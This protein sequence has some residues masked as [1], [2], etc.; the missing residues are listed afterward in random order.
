M[1]NKTQTRELKTYAHTP[2][3][4]PYRGHIINFPM[5]WHYKRTT[6]WERLPDK[7]RH[8][9]MLN[10]L[11][12]LSSPHL[13]FVAYPPETEGFLN[14]VIHP[15]FATWWD[16]PEHWKS[17]LRALMSKLDFGIP[18]RASLSIRT[19]ARCT[20]NRKL[21]DFVRPGAGEMSIACVCFCLFSNLHA[22]KGRLECKNE[23]IWVKNN[24]Q[25]VWGVS[26]DCSE[27]V[28]G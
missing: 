20:V 22:A 10:V 17:E 8:H 7:T 5:T 12:D 13:F 11:A 23:I 18:T 15:K 27:L 6:D 21:N 28:G 16:E 1:Y 14:P 2:L 19:F 9:D 26:N 3:L 25:D 24:G 4:Y